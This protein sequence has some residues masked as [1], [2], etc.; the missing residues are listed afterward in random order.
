MCS[1]LRCCLCSTGAHARALQ[2]YETHVRA[3]WGGG[4]NAAGL[5]NACYT[6]AQ[7]VF[8]QVKIRGYFF[9]KNVFLVSLTARL[10]HRIYRSRRQNS[11]TL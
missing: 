4:L 1:S 11:P 3:A 5:R 9:P 8:L 2:H 6:D 10:V 7:V